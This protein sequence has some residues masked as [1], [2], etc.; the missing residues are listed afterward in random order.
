[1]FEQNNMN[2]KPSVEDKLKDVLSGEML[3][4]ALGFVA[5]LR[6][7]GM[8]SDDDNRFYYKGEFTCIL[9]FFKDNNFS[10]GLWVVCDCPIEEYDGFPLSEDLK[11]FARANVKICTGECGCP[12]WPRGGDKM[13][14]GQEYKSI[15]SSEIQ[16]LNPDAEALVN[17]KMLMDYWKLMIDEGKYKG[18]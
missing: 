11:E 2:N 15:C 14:F 5:H 9:V 7:V 4:N 18:R 16:F 3:E 12:D 1:M 10:D 6:S 13:V 17:V 8:T